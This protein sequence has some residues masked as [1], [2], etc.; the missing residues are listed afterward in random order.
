MLRAGV[1]LAAVL[2]PLQILLG[3]LH[4]LNTLEHQPAKI[5]AIEGIWQTQAGAPL[6]LLG[7][8]DEEDG[9]TRF[10]VEIP[11]AA[12]RLA[13]ELAVR[14]HIRFVRRWRDSD[15]AVRRMLAA[16]ALGHA[17]GVQEFAPHAHAVDVQFR[18]R[19]KGP[20]RVLVAYL[21]VLVSSPHEYWKTGPN[22]KRAH[23]PR[24]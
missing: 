16:P 6:T 24:L 21:E 4:G 1:L 9:R 19:C 18:A 5:A 23:L 20:Q 8:P 7:I 10:A 13:Y 17:V 3:D 2:T 14:E 11:R 22:Q 12:S 15:P